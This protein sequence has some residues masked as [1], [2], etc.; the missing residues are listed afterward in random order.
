[1]MR[2]LR[3]VGRQTH[4][5]TASYVKWMAL[6]HNGRR[7]PGEPCAQCGETMSDAQVAEY[8]RQYRPENE[9]VVDQQEARRLY[10]EAINGQGA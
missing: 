4:P 5:N 9:G 7:L 10:L 2:T 3:N 6:T 8:L 1:M